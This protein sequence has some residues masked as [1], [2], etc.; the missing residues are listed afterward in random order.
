M[1]RLKINHRRGA[2]AVRLLPPGDQRL[3]KQAAQGFPA[4]ESQV[5]LAARSG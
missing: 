1:F 3:A 4:I 5:A 2:I